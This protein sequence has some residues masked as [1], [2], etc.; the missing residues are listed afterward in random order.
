[1]SFEKV[2]NDLQNSPPELK[3]WLKI[4]NDFTLTAPVNRSLKTSDNWIKVFKLIDS[5]LKKKYTNLSTL[6]KSFSQFR[7]P[8]KKEKF[9][10]IYNNSLINMG[11]GQKAS[12]KLKKTYKNEVHLRNK[13]IIDLPEIHIEDVKDLIEFLF[14]SK[15]I[16]D[17]VIALLLST[18]SRSIEILKLS[19]FN[20]VKGEPQKIKISNL[21]KSNNSTPLKRNLIVLTPSQ[22]INSI[23][24]IRKKL[25]FQ[26]LTNTQIADKVNKKL[27][28]KFKLGMSKIIDTEDIKN[29]N[30]LKTLTAHK[31][32]YIYGAV[33]WNLYGKDKKIPYESYIQE[34]IGH[35]NPE[36]TKS[37]LA[38]N[39]APGGNG[40]IQQGE[41][42]HPL[43]KIQRVADELKFLNFPEEDVNLKDLQKKLGVS[44]S[45]LSMGLKLFQL[46]TF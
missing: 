14:E 20:K 32:R 30:Y 3:L 27:N 33:S 46:Q 10:A 1:M 41:S 35:V 8:L 5:L 12:L 7:K 43:D 4:F 37:Y 24:Y 21:A 23:R 38:I 13:H 6:N 44:Q 2:L 17:Q 29:K 25:N 39:I 45:T 26:N 19:S 31:T 42:K 15:D 36:S 9:T 22:I 28:R 16:Y 40:F 11:I 34:Q 18:G